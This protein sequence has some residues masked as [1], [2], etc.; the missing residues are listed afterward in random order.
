MQPKKSFHCD[1]ENSPDDQYGNKV[2][3]MKCHG[4]LVSDTA[5][6]LKELVKPLAAV[7]TKK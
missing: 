7:Q 1:L 3:T 5:G 4:R 2:K 6:E